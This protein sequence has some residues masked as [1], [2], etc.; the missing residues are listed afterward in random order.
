MLPKINRSHQN[1]LHQG[2]SRQKGL[3][4]IEVMV[5]FFIL[6]TGIL[7]AVAMQASSKKG[8]F[9]AMQR[10][11]ASSLAQDILERMRSNSSSIAVLEAYE[12]TYGATLNAVP[13]IRC[14]SADSLC[15]NQNMVVNDLYE[16]ELGIMGADVKNGE[17]STGGLLDGSACITHLNNQVRIVI[18]WQGREAT[19]DAYSAADYNS[20]QAN[21]SALAASCGQ[22]G[23]KRRQVAIEAFIF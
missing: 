15:S 7:G 19:S 2:K 11:V 16:W 21:L 22:A 20:Q 6:V 18:S 17:D 9:D 10:S 1:C 13:E 4:L 3:T 12:G 5:A 23:N 8:S 14:N